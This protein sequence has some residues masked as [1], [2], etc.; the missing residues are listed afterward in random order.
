MSK[1][2]LDLLQLTAG[3]PAHLRA[4]T[5]E[6]VGRDARHANRLSVLL[7]QLPD[8]LLAKGKGANPVATI[9]RAEHLATDHARSLGPRIDRFFNPGRHRNGADAPV[10]ADEVHDAPPGVPL[11]DVPEGD[12][13]HLRPSQAASQEY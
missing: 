4:G 2:Q 5:T 7:E 8:D 13:R 10:L 9:H 1:E 3:G 11:L 12:R 6:V